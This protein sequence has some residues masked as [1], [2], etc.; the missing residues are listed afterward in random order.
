MH[1]TQIVNFLISITEIGVHIGDPISE[2][3]FK[4]TRGTLKPNYLS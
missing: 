2:T 4:G 3:L 1:F